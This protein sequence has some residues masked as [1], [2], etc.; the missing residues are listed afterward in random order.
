MSIITLRPYQE[1][2]VSAVR[3]AYQQD[4]K[5][6]LLVAPTGSGKTVVF[7]YIAASASLRKKRVLI[8]VHRI[9]LLR[10]T[11]TALA[12]FGVG[13]GLINP[14][15][16]SDLSQHVQVAS[17]QTLI[18]RLAKIHPPD[19]IITDE[20]HH[21][22]SPTT[23]KILDYFP[24]A[25][26]LGVTATPCR[27]DG[28]GLGVNAGGI[29]DE[30]IYGPTVKELIR[31]GYLVA[32][33]VYTA[34][35]AIDLINVKI[36]QGDYD[37]SELSDLLNKRHITGQA[38]AHYKQLCDGEPAVVFCSDVKHAQDVAEDFNAAGYM[39]ASVDGTMDDA[40][41]SRIL[42]GLADGTIQVVTSADLISEGTDIPAIGCAILLRPT[43]STGLYIQQV[44]RAL[45]PSPGKTKAIILDHVGNVLRHGMPDEDREW[46][47]EGAEKKTKGSGE[48]QIS[49]SICKSCY[50]AYLPQPSCPYCGHIEPA[51][52]RAPE[53][54]SGELVE[55]TPEHAAYLKEQKKVM[56]GKAKTL[57]ELQDVGKQLGYD[58]R[59]AF[60]TW[61]ARQSKKGQPAN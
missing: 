2:A 48:A 35:K 13:H 17:V 42:A 30:L 4:K 22:T 44:G 28:A 31:L 56:V 25:R 49:V 18:R 50:A 19:V 41:R 58:G 39:A 5:A 21:A 57:Q 47:L 1:K 55:M 34:K 59:W 20:C 16:N 46:S 32:P 53:V 10:Q 61:K 26:I 24:A 14:K 60:M 38:I 33:V 12:G 15:Y 29:F 45:R 6:P 54:V 3:K 11:S 23:R 52:E 8:L 9:E 36:R 37:R 7:C 27:T 40:D 51:K 43:K